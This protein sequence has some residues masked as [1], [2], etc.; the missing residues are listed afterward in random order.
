M[1]ILFIL[2]QI[3]D[4]LLFTVMGKNRSKTRKYAR[5]HTRNYSENLIVGV[6]LIIIFSTI[7]IKSDESVILFFCAAIYF[8]C[9][10][11]KYDRCSC[12]CTSAYMNC[13]MSDDLPTPPP[14]TVTTLYTGGGASWPADV[15]NVVEHGVPEV[16]CG[17]SA[18]TAVDWY[19]TH[20][21]DAEVLRFDA[22][23]TVCR[24]HRW[25][26]SIADEGTRLQG[27]KA[28]IDSDKDCCWQ[29]VAESAVYGSRF[30]RWCGYQ[31]TARARHF[32]QAPVSAL[33]LTAAAASDGQ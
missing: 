23:P 4:N 25:Q 32:C 20:P 15:D 26:V 30:G 1:H 22:S 16:L 27:L 2:G 21:F 9:D 7:I 17:G 11:R 31:L 6:I 19:S 29:L 18:G 24:N 10:L 28:R 13:T 14:P 33:K 5:T 12:C 8:F 3:V